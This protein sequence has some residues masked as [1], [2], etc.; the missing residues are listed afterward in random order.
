MLY[1]VA[2]LLDDDDLVLFEFLPSLLGTLSGWVVELPC[3]LLCQ[4]PLTCQTSDFFSFYFDCP[5]YFFG[6]PSHFFFSFGFDF[7]F[8]DFFEFYFWVKLCLWGATPW[9]LSISSQPTTN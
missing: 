7:Y 4:L 8:C 1:V 2:T 5:S 6:F 3:V 9:L